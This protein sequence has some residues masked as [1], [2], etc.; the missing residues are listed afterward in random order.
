[1]EGPLNGDKG[2]MIT[3]L[4]NQQVMQ[5]S[6]CLRRADN[7]QG[8]GKGKACALLNVPRGKMAHYMHHIKTKI[9]YTSLKIQHQERQQKEYPKLGG[10]GQ[11]QD[12]FS[13][14]VETEREAGDFDT[15]EDSL[16]NPIEKRDAKIASLEK[17]LSDF[18]LVQQ[19]LKHKEQELLLA[20]KNSRVARNKL[21]HVKKV[22]EQRML[23]CIPDPKFKDDYSHHLA[24]IW[25]T[26]EDADNYTINAETD[27]LEPS[28]EDALLKDLRKNCDMSVEENKDAIKYLRNKVLENV[29]ERVKKTNRRRDSSASSITSLS[30]LTSIRSKRKHES[31]LPQLEQKSSK[32]ASD[33]KS[34]LPLPKPVQ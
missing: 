6:N 11:E 13:G 2:A 3:V 5:C 25:A 33:S 21:V 14:M 32:L 29:K 22:A 15:E 17:R 20:Q 24:S 34:S 1:M 4:H 19:Q 10:F 31:E 16:A 12:A 23:E 9:G 28:D 8:G 26:C 7:C 27:I 18:N 30:S